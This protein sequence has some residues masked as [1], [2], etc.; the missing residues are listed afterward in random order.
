MFELVLEL[1]GRSLLLT[2]ILVVTACTVSTGL[3]VLVLGGVHA[4]LGFR[5]G[6]CFG[7]GRIGL[8]RLLGFLLIVCLHQTMLRTITILISIY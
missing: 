7:E 2:E 1:A 3:L 8:N 6:G 5:V 4:L